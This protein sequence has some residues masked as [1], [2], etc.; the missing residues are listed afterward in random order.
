[1]RMGKTNR[2]HTGD[3]GEERDDLP[4]TRS[5]NRLSPRRLAAILL[6]AAAELA[7]ACKFPIS[8][9]PVGPAIAIHAP[10]GLPPVPAPADNPPTAA[11]IALGRRLFYDTSLS[12]D[13][14]LACSSCHSPLFRFSD[15]RERSIGVGGKLGLR[16]APTLVNVAYAKLLF[17]DGRAANLETQVLSPMADPLEMN[18]SHETSVGKLR[19]NPAYR[20]LFLAAFGTDDITIQRVENALASFERTIL[21]GNSVFDRYQYGGQKDALT[22]EQIRGLAVFSDPKRGNCASCH[23]IG[24]TSALFTDN[25][26]HNTGEGV[27]DN[28]EIDDLGRFVVTRRDA[29]KG[30]FKTPTLRDVAVSGPYMHDGKLKTLKAVVDFYAGK[31]NSNPYLDPKMKTINLT[32][33]DRDDLVEFMKSLNSDLPASLGPPQKGDSQ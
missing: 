15:A 2:T 10:L 16:H 9:K 17:W 19:D 8:A 14:S 29:D 13:N 4:R 23:T 28:D 11:E 6:F 31:G 26:F 22:P 5:R 32:G 12:K 30:A 21:C 20:D 33:T 25:Q 18:Q 27:G 1:M 3:G 7:S 24:A